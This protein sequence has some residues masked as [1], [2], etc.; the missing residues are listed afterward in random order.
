MAATW[1]DAKYAT[2]I[3]TAE[4]IMKLLGQ[5]RGG[6]SAVDVKCSNFVVLDEP[7]TREQLAQ[8]MQ[9]TPA[10]QRA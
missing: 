8:A 2:F 1:I 7:V 3:G 4:Q 9:T 10:R 5:L 6:A